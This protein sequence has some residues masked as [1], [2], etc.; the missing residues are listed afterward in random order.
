[1]GSFRGSNLKRCSKIA[2]KISKQLRTE[3]RQQTTQSPYP[4]W[5]R[6]HQRKKKRHTVEWKCR[7]DDERL[8]KE[9][10]EKVNCISLGKS[11]KYTQQ[12]LRA[13]D[14]HSNDTDWWAGHK[15][16]FLFYFF[17]PYKRQSQK[18]ENSAKYKNS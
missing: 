9:K 15:T 6:F 7:K 2:L 3:P 13:I 16:K 10:G 18:K 12:F 8:T 14:D 1:M 17:S 5:W 11:F 4:R